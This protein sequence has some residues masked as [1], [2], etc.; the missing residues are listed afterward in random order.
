MRA[1][2]TNFRTYDAP[3]ATKVRLLITNNLTKARTRANCCGHPG[4]P[5]C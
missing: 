3:L 4:Q 5:G 1:V 2:F